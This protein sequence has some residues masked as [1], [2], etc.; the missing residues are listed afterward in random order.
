VKRI[1]LIGLIIIIGILGVLAYAGLSYKITCALASSPAPTTAPTPAPADAVAT[2]TPISTST[3]TP[4]QQKELETA[5]RDILG[6]K[7]LAKPEDPSFESVSAYLPA[8]RPRAPR[9]RGLLRA[10]LRL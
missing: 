5:D 2:T 3:L 7:E 8:W 6:D 9:R 10:N 1:I 4:S